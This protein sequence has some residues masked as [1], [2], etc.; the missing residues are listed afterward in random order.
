MYKIDIA[1][2]F[3][4]YCVHVC[5]WMTG[6]GVMEQTRDDIELP[7]HSSYGTERSEKD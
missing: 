6:C 4:K 1:R 3:V 2:Y 7:F 5:V